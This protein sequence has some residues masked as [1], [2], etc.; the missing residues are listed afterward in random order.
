QEQVLD[1]RSVDE[2]HAGI[3]CGR[4]GPVMRLLARLDALYEENPLAQA[5]QWILPRSG[6][7]G[8]ARAAE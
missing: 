8:K 1:R 7:A 4:R 2:A 5:T 6:L 3:P